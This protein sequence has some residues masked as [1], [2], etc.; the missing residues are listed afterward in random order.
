MG[1]GVEGTARITLHEHPR[2]KVEVGHYA[3]ALGY[4]GSYHR[5]TSA[6]NH[7]HLSCYFVWCTVAPSKAQGRRAYHASFHLTTGCLQKMYQNR[8]RILVR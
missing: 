5:P 4:A 8:I 2:V 1:I 7:C 6:N 3:A